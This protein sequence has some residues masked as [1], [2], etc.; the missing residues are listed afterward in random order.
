MKKYA[1]VVAFPERLYDP[2]QQFYVAYVETENVAKAIDKGEREAWMRQP[3]KERG[4]IVEWRFVLV[5]EGHPKL[6]A[7]T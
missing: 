3:P 5:F 7:L 4:S 1:V 6:E 2:D